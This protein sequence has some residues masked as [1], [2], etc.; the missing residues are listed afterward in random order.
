MKAEKR[1]IYKT[2]ISIPKEGYGLCNICKYAIFNGVCDDCDLECHCGIEK[3]EEDAYGTW[4][5]DDCWAFQPRWSLADITDMVGIW[6]QGKQPDMSKC[7]D[8]M[9]LKVHCM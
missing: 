4:S 8:R 5:G 1:E 9:P 6:L 2:L 3:V 7:E